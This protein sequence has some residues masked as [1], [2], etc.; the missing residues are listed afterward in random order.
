MPYD[1]LSAA[2]ASDAAGGTGVLPLWIR[3]LDGRMRIVGQVSGEIRLGEV[4]VR[5]GDYV[6]AD[7][8]GIVI[9]PQEQLAELLKRARARLLADQQRERDLDAQLAARS[10]H[11]QS[12]GEQ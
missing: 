6:I 4:V 12:D 5:P 11:A 1:W 3:P 10:P 9:W 2:L 8:D 7:E